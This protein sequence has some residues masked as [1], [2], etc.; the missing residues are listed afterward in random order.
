MIRL[1]SIYWLL[2][3]DWLLVRLITIWLLDI[4]WLWLRLELLK[5]R[6]RHVILLL[7]WLIEG[8]IEFCRNVILGFDHLFQSCCDFSLFRFDAFYFHL[9][10]MYPIGQS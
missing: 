10:F 3:R 1:S 2:I 5:S 4:I 7:L 8:S 9:V 6:R